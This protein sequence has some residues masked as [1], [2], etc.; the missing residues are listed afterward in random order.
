MFEGEPS[1]LASPAATFFSIL[2]RKRRRD[3]EVFYCREANIDQQHTPFP[4]LRLCKVHGACYSFH[5]TP[6]TPTLPFTCHTL[7]S[8]A[9]RCR[10]PPYPAA[11]CR[12][13]PHPAVPF[14]T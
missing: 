4:R 14:H 2:E 13:L 7:P 6:T 12:T 9:I 5:S 1:L 3:I 11:R 10:T 8:P